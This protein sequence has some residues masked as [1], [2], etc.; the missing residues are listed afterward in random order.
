MK[1]VQ[2][3]SAFDKVIGV[4]QNSKDYKYFFTVDLSTL[5]YESL[6]LDEG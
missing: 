3:S 6:I 2:F 5:A 4:A 1:D